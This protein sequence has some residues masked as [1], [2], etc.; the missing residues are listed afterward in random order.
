M[1]RMSWT[2][3]EGRFFDTGIDRGV[4]YPKSVPPLGPI[5]TIN[6]AT[7]P[8][9]EK[10]EVTSTTIFTNTCKVPLP[11]AVTGYVAAGGATV[12]YDAGA[13]GIRVTAAAG[14]TSDAGVKIADGWLSSVNPGEIWLYSIEVE[15]VIAG[16]YK[17]AISGTRGNNTPAAVSFAAGETKRLTIVMTHTGSGAGV[18]NWYAYR[19]STDAAEFIVRKAMQIKVGSM[20]AQAPDYFDGSTRTGRWNHPD[21]ATAWVSTAN[22]SNSILRTVEVPTGVSS[23][24][25]GVG[26]A[27]SKWASDDSESLEVVGISGSDSFATIDLLSLGLEEGRPYTIKARARQD[28]A[29]AGAVQGPTQGRNLYVAVT[30]GGGALRLLSNDAAHVNAAGE[31]QNKVTFTVPKIV[32]DPVTALTL[33]FYN[34]HPPGQTNG[35]WWDEL[36]IY[37]GNA[38]IPFFDGDTE[39]TALNTFEWAGAVDSSR[40]YRRERKYVAV[41]WIGLTGVDEK[42]GEGAASYYIDGRPFLF[43]PKPKEYQATLRAYTYPDEFAAIMGVTEVADGMYLDSQ[44]GESFDLSYRTLVGNA[45]NG[46]DHGYKIHLVYNAVVT[47]QSLSYDT[48]GSSINPVEFAWDIQAVPVR[49]EGFRPTAHII[50][51]TRHMDP[52]RIAAI[53]EMLY[54]SDEVL[55]SMPSPQA[56]FDLLSYGDTII[57][58]D[59]GDG[60]F[61]VEGAYENVY[62]VSPG[63]FRVDN[64]DGTNYPDGTFVISSTN[65]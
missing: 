35:I 52:A 23:N 55:P 28:G 20:S 40:S 51:D 42:G 54:G 15:A 6:L 37:E 57:V 31:Y 48:L 19:G 65:V 1:P 64:V 4:L 63:E 46:L 49:V 41:P 44:P 21:Y 59:M 16:T 47:P 53:E 56:V 2:A 58:T 32:G 25:S 50:I 62:M 17:I 43:L 36:L 30:G 8:S 61:T 24:S 14:G 26:L 9:F 13:S 27:S 22:Q 3:P 60:T 45:V 39:M 18:V 5:E 12:A 33:R 10:K 38:D 29:L 7:N 34:G 11:V